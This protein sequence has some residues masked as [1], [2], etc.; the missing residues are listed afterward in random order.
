MYKKNNFFV[1]SPQNLHTRYKHHTLLVNKV[2]WQSKI[3]LSL[4]E[5]K[6]EVLTNFAK[7]IPLTTHCRLAYQR[8][9][10]RSSEIPTLVGLHFDLNKVFVFFWYS[11]FVTASCNLQKYWKAPKARQLL[12][13]HSLWV[14]KQGIK[15]HIGHIYWF[16]RNIVP[17]NVIAAQ[18]LAALR[19]E[20][21]FGVIG[22]VG[23]LTLVF[24]CK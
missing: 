1:K 20:G 10:P 17:T 23:R 8:T 4:W 15:W 7:L 21:P 13:L 11:I 18:L 6:N 14:Q 24:E 5:E 3:F 22:G 9:P 19:K 16:T 12:S 2:W